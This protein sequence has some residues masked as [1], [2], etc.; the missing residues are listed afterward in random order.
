M[1]EKESHEP[2]AA[3][4]D[5]RNTEDQ[6]PNNAASEGF[7]AA[8]PKEPVDTSDAGNHF[9]IVGIG[10]SAGGLDA[11]EQFFTHLPAEPG[12][13]FVVVQHLDPT[14]KSILAD[15]VQGH[16]RMQV[17]EVEDGVKVKPNCVYIIP[18]D[19]DMGMLHATLQ[20]MQPTARRGLRLPIDFFFRSFSQDQR[21]RAIGVVLSG[22]G[23]DGTLGL[24]AVKE[25]GGMVMV[26]DPETAKYNGMPKSAIATGLVDFVLPASEMAKQLIAY[27]RHAFRSGIEKPTVPKPESKDELQKIFFQ[28]RS[29]TGHDFSAYKP[30]T[31]LRRIERRMTVN[32]IERLTDYVRYLQ[33]NPLEVQTLFKELL[34]GVSNFFR[35]K[36][37]FDALKEKIIPAL[38]KNRS[39]E[40]VRVWVP[41]CATGEEAYSIAILLREQMELLNQEVKVQ[42][43]ATDIDSTAIEVARSGVYP[44]SI[45]ADVSPERLRR[46]FT[47]TDGNYQVN[48]NLRDMLVFAEQSIIKDPPFSKLDL[49]S[50]RNLLIYI[51]SNLQKKLLPVFHYALNP[52]GYL[53]LG[54]S[55]SIGEFTD[56][57]CVIDRKWKLFQRK[58]EASFQRTGFQLPNLFLPLTATDRGVGGV[59]ETRKAPSFREVCERLLL[60]HYTPAAVLITNNGEILYVHGQTGK[61]LELAAGE[62]NLNIVRMAR[63]GLGVDLTT[64]IRKAVTQ[65]QPIRYKGLRV[66]IN[67]K[68]QA[69]DL[70]VT[71]VSRE[72]RLSDAMLVAFEEVSPEAPTEPAQA[73]ESD[74]N[75]T[76]R[77]KD[78]EHELRSTKEYLQTTIE[79]LETSNEELKSTNEELQSSNEE[80]QSINQELETSKEELQSVN[81]ELVTVNTEHE[82]KLE[83]LAKA[84]NDMA[85]LFESTDIGIIFLDTDL[86][87]QRFTPAATRVVKLIRSDIGRPLTD[88]ASTLS[89]DDLL[90]HEV[91][92][93]L[94]TLKPKEKEVQTVRG[95]WYSVRVRPYRTTENVIDGALINFVDITD[96]KRAQE[97]LRTL[98]QAVEQS[99]N[100]IIITNT[101]GTIKYVNPHF[102]RSSGY[103]AEEAVGQ[104]PSILKSGKMSQRVFEEMWQALK[105]GSTWQGELCNKRKDGTLYWDF[106]S[107]SPVKNE[108]GEV[109]HLVGIQREITGRKEADESLKT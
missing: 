71:P 73:R 86:C 21:E 89:D 97:Q 95:M 34:I 32:Q 38:F 43:F 81:E 109:T 60:K 80:L 102:T 103:T 64:A 79:E 51:G 22:T 57:F 9:P 37:A 94:Q 31:I 82:V 33:H 66:K 41:G 70:S 52:S 77:I 107:I 42:V 40:P 106:V 25:E 3:E 49:L 13:A 20:L 108:K 39:M 2:Q 18:P 48:K 12:M 36:E 74:K 68:A 65:R 30:N 98:S 104:R 7:E 84:N 8:A 10:A 101:E 47:K 6:P 16:T 69:F 61:Y 58:Q 14:H 105:I 99:L 26:Q 96:Q 72:K 88:F 93:V 56:L 11:L 45:A 76:Q 29:Q 100:S 92:E 1:V 83:E 35:D 24:K 75:N 5:H 87:I 44:I 54:S 23:S 27:L 91:T 59:A 55:E 17:F 46:F 62:A 67:D 4:K 28:L 63:E 15:L 78:L 19:R 53:F 50:C 90:V 85:N